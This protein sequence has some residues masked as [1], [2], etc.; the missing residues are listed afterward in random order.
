MLDHPLV[1]VRL[2]FGR[3]TID[4]EREIRLLGDFQ[5]T[6]AMNHADEATPLTR[7]LEFRH[8]Q[9]ERACPAD[10]TVIPRE[11]SRF[12]A[13]GDERHY[14]VGAAADKATWLR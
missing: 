4:F 10:R 1:D 14:P 13:R 12:A 3:R 8:F 9:P 11:Y 7:I 6:S 2:G 5:G